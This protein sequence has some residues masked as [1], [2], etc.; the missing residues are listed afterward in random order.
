[1]NDDV[2]RGDVLL[3]CHFDRESLSAARSAVYSS[4][5]AAGAP[6]GPAMA[7][8]TGV[9]EGMKQR[10]RARQ[11]VRRVTTV[12]QTGTAAVAA[13]VHDLGS[14]GPFDVPAKPPPPERLGGRGLW[15]ASQL[16]DRVLVLSGRR[17]TSVILELSFA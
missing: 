8:T 12:W 10:D 1:M 3:E 14:G 6:D 2:V 9:A 15:L 4:V 11:W 13:E 17:G 5:V 7:F 16:C